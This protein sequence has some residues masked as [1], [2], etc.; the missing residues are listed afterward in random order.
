VVGRL[1]L[2]HGVALAQVQIYFDLEGRRCH[3]ISYPV[4][5]R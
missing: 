3:S 2:A 5:L 4:R 1:D